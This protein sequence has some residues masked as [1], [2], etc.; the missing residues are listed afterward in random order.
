MKIFNT[1]I[2]VALLVVAAGCQSDH[3][4][5]VSQS[6][7]TSQPTAQT[8]APPQNTPP[9][10]A[11][12]EPK[13]SSIQEVKTDK[14]TYTIE[15]IPSQ[16][17]TPTSREGDKATQIYSSNIIAVYVHTNNSVTVSSTN[18]TLVPAPANNPP[19]QNK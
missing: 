3:S 16:R 10:I 1:V 18:A 9:A 11:Q 14:I 17:L 15:T 13:P 6:S 12:Q 19:P 5:T 8:P 4:R 7:I 2:P